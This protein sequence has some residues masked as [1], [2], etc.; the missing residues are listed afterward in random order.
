MVLDGVEEALELALV[1]AGAG[2]AAGAAAAAGEGVFEGAVGDVF[3]AAA[4]GVDVPV[5]AVAPNHV[6][7]PLCP[8][9]PPCL[10]APL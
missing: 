9:H 8:R 10:V 7:I 4:L 2:A 1:A 6:F 5:A 3:E